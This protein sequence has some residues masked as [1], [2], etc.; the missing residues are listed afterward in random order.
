[1]ITIQVETIDLLIFCTFCI[2][3]VV[4][5]GLVMHD[6]KDKKESNDHHRRSDQA[7][8]R[9]SRRVSK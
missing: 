6:F 3:W 8:E 9:S 5:K 4:V 2:V 1:M 7:G